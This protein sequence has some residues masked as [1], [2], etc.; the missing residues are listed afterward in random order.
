MKLNRT[1]MRIDHV[2]DNSRCTRKNRTFMITAFF[3][4]PIGNNL[5]S[6]TFELPIVSADRF[7]ISRLAPASVGDY[8]VHLSDTPMYSSSAQLR[9]SARF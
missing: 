2:A 1:A 8:V 4:Q 5:F 7:K 3:G 6:G 9:I